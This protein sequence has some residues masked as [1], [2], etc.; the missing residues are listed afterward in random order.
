[1]DSI[2]EIHKLLKDKK[3]SANELVKESLNKANKYKSL[4]MFNTLTAEQ[5]I[6]KFNKNRF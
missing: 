6:E 5:A 1:M 2:I 3:I 4:N